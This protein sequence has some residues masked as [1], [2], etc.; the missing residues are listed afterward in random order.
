ME[1]TEIDIHALYHDTVGILVM[2]IHAH[3][4]LTLQVTMAHW[5]CTVDVLNLGHQNN[6]T[7]A[8]NLVATPSLL[9]LIL[10][11]LEPRYRGGGR[12]CLASTD[13][14]AFWESQ[15]SLAVSYLQ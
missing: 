10:A 2:Q 14:P 6:T 4:S 12:E 8:Q 13:F 1:H 9:G 11:I 15:I 3:Q 7:V 5:S